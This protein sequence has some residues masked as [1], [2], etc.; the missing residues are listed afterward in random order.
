MNSS[1]AIINREEHSIQGR[2]EYG[3]NFIVIFGEQLKTCG[4]V[5]GDGPPSYV[6]P[7]RSLDEKTFSYQITDKLPVGSSILGFFHRPLSFE[8]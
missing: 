8:P 6:V 4:W 3:L 1:L 5:P 2:E 7:K